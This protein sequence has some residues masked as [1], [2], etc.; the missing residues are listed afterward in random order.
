[1]PRASAVTESDWAIRGAG[2]FD[3]MVA[4]LSVAARCRPQVARPCPR[5]GCNMNFQRGVV[6]RSDGSLRNS[7]TSQCW[8]ALGGR[9]PAAD[10][11][12]VRKRVTR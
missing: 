10:G 3:L 5:R 7:N 1:M 4:G 12:I 8:R 6:K 2:T 9:L 11:A